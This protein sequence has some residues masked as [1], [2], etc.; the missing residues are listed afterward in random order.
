MEGIVNE[1]VLAWE[2]VG[3]VG[4]RHVPCLRTFLVGRVVAISPKEYVWMDDFTV[5]DGNSMI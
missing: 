3:K 2:L 4:V 1:R 5:K